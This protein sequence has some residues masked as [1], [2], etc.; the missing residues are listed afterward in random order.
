MYFPIC[1]FRGVLSELYFP[2][3]IISIR[4]LQFVFYEL[5]LFNANFPIVQHFANFIFCSD[6]Y[7]I[8]INKVLHFG[9]FHEFH[10]ILR[11][12]LPDLNFPSCVPDLYFRFPDLSFRIVCSDMYCF[13]L[14]FP[15]YMFSIYMFRFVCSD[16]Y[17]PTCSLRF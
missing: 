11:F 14:Y 6:I 16:L 7:K 12:V 4:I 2:I 8:T 5:Y 17:F 1:I 15:I 13:D 3:C 9:W 10:Y